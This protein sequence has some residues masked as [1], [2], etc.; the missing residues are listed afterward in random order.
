[1]FFRN[2]LLDTFFLLVQADFAASGTDIA[3]V[4]ICHFTRT[5]YDTSHDTDLETFQMRGCRLDAC[6]GTFQVIQCTSAT[7]TRNIFSL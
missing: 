1:M 4:S 5:V 6:D 2:V 7:R 3:I